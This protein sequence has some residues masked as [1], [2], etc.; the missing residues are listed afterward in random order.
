MYYWK[1]KQ[2][3]TFGNALY[4]GFSAILVCLFLSYTSHKPLNQCLWCWH[5]LRN[6]T[7][8]SGVLSLIWYTQVCLFVNYHPF[9]YS[10]KLGVIH[11]LCW[12]QIYF[13]YHYLTATSVLLSNNLN[14]QN[15][16]I[17]QPVNICTAYRGSYFDDRRNTD[18]SIL[19]IWVPLYYGKNKIYGSQWLSTNFYLFFSE[20][21]G[22]NR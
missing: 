15:M 2:L 3:S 19:S 9:H 17:K 14:D 21:C 10:D 6:D 12:K 13:F 4:A 22:Q 11:F 18:F 1:K 16:P 8:W 7:L 5:I 20:D